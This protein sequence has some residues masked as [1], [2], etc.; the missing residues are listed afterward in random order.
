MIYQINPTEEKPRGKS[1]R[2][3]DIFVQHIRLRRHRALQEL[4]IIV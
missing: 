4:N 2:D 1:D 3:N